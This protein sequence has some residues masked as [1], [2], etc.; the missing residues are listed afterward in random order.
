MIADYQSRKNQSSFPYG[1]VWA[2]G[3]QVYIKI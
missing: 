3:I 2:G 1:I